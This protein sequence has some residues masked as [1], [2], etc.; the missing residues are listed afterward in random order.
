MRALAVLC[1]V[2]VIGCGEQAPDGAPQVAA[3]DPDGVADRWAVARGPRVLAR[4]ECNRCHD[5]DGVEPPEPA[6][7]CAGCHRKIMAGEMGTSDAEREAWQASVVSL[8]EVPSLTGTNR[9]RRGFLVSLLQDGH[10]MRPH[11]RPSM[12]RFEMPD[13]D[14]EAIAAVLSPDASAPAPELGDPKR[15]RAV[16]ERKGCGVCHRF[17]GVPAL[18]AD[19]RVDVSA[20]ALA[21]GQ[22]LAPDLRW[23]RDRLRPEAVILWLDDPSSVKADAAMPELPMT[24]QE[25]ADAAAYLLG[26]PLQDTPHREP[27]APPPLLDREVRWDEVKERVFGNVCQHCHGSADFVGDGGP[28]YAGGFGFEARKLDLSS[29]PGLLRG[30]VGDDG[31]RRS[32]LAPAEGDTP[33]IVQHLWAR[34]AEEAGQPVPGV[35]GMPLGL[36]PLPPDDITLVH[37][38]ITQG[39]RR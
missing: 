2:L 18:P 1:G 22:Q 6:L 8:G 11:L 35:R 21:R 24:E 25:V 28:G 12:P 4:Y 39:R 15:G 20:Q 7:D 31:R 26:A 34:H 14:A 10:D 36:P 9:F 27:P 3:A 13:G 33:R 30:S 17:T 23:T 5:I 19:G 29:Y 37:T 16:L 32:V 38:W